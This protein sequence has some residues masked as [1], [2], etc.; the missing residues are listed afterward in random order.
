MPEHDPKP[1]QPTSE[2]A[3]KNP[4]TQNNPTGYTKNLNAEQVDQQRLHK[5]AERAEAQAA[6]LESQVNDLQRQL[7]QRQRDIDAAE[8]RRQIDQS[9]T[10]AGAVDLETA[11]LLVES[12]IDNAHHD[13]PDVSQAVADL[14][15][16]KPFLFRGASP[17]ASSA[18]SPRAASPDRAVADAA[19][20]AAHTGDRTSLLRYLRARRGA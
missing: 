3:D 13:S 2:P 7:D 4:T 8:R 1:D 17:P 11:R 19:Q 9:L 10:D 16:R 15:R 18:M 12:T 20:T 5:R 6:S 14:R